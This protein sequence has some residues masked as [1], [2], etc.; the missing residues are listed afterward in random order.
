MN[1]PD[2][3]LYLFVRKYNKMSTGKVGHVVRIDVCRSPV[4]LIS[5]LSNVLC[6]SLV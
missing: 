6:V 1:K 5:Y 3:E 2:M 4:N